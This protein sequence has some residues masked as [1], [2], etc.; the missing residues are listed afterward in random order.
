MI[1]TMDGQGALFEQLARAL[2]RE[3]LG[4]GFEPASQL[5]A[6]RTLAAALGVSRNTVLGAYELLC[7]EQL[8]VAHLNWRGRAAAAGALRGARKPVPVRAQSRWAYGRENSAHSPF[9]EWWWST[10][11]TGMRDPLYV[12]G[13]RRGA[14]YVRRSAPRW[15][16]RISTCRV[17]TSCGCAINNQYNGGDEVFPALRMM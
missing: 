9:L 17:W 7:A 13:R 11:R 6:T 1:L 2:K 10:L 15:K 4:G 3:I 8:A 14:A 12:S 16:C 5:P